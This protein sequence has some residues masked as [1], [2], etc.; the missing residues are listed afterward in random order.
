MVALNQPCT[1]MGVLTSY[2]C[3]SCIQ[4]GE[5]DSHIAA[6][7]S[8]F[9]PLVNFLGKARQLSRYLVNSQHFTSQSWV[10]MAVHALATKRRIYLHTSWYR[11]RWGKLLDTAV[12]FY[13]AQMVNTKYHNYKH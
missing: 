12:F 10:G 9:C 13:S 5:G 2:Q 4:V 11:L 8:V 6:H 1:K 3:K 7:V